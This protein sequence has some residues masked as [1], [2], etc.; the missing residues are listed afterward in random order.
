MFK[1]ILNLTGIQ[2]VYNN[3]KEGMM[4][5]RTTDEQMQQI[6]QRAKDN[7]FESVSSFVKYVAL[8]AVVTATV[9]TNTKR[10]DNVKVGVRKDGS[11]EVIFNGEAIEE[12]KVKETLRQIAKENGIDITT[13]NNRHTEYNTREVGHIIIKALG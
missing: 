5:I 8:N 12:G 10:L 7:G 13:R 6:E 1:S 11:I 3:K 4:N 2:C 9:P